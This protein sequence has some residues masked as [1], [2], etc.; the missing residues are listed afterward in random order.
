MVTG[1]HAQAGREGLEVGAVGAAA[2]VVDSHAVGGN[3]L[4]GCVG[5][6]VVEQGGPVGGF[7]GLDFAGGAAGSLEGGMGGVGGDIGG[8]GDFVDVVSDV[9]GIG[10]RVDA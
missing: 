7:V 10:D 9:A 6:L 3:F 4:E 8:A 5:V 1:E 2:E